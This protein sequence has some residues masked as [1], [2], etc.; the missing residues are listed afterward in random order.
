MPKTCKL[1]GERDGLG[2]AG[3]VG[4][5]LMLGVGVLVVAFAFERG[6]GRGNITMS[7][8]K[9]TL[10]FKPKRLLQ[11]AVQVVVLNQDPCKPLLAIVAG[12]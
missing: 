9:R 4:W 11:E 7:V 3:L 5:I 2:G 1:C 6:G 8:Y 12:A 10:I